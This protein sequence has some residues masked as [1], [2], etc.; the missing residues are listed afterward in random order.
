M[1]LSKLLEGAIGA[2]GH[3]I[4]DAA[5]EIGVAHT[6][7]S[8]WMAGEVLPR[9]RQYQAIADYCRTDLNAV[10]NAIMEQEAAGFDI[11][12]EIAKRDA[13]IARLRRALNAALNGGQQQDP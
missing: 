4:A 2:R 1:K 5:E 11:G 9:R 3:G 13:E 8:R 10:I 6:T 7:V 12:G